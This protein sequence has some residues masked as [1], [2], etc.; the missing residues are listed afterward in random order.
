MC[1]RQETRSDGFCLHARHILGA[2]RHLHPVL[3][4]A[5]KT[6]QHVEERPAESS[7]RGEVLEMEAQASST[8]GDALEQQLTS[9]VEADAEASLTG[10]AGE[11]LPQT[12]MQYTNAFSVLTQWPRAARAHPSLGLHCRPHTF[13]PALA[14]HTRLPA[15]DHP[16]AVLQ[17]LGRCSSSHMQ[18]LT[19]Q[20]GENG[21]SPS[22][23]YSL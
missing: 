1:V 10:E 13:R 21:R 8:R 6:R 22:S 11:Q 4:A 3:A 17:H 20:H 19:F 18:P 9:Q 14:R 5:K 2:C 7:E 15:T 23:T 16:M 12:G